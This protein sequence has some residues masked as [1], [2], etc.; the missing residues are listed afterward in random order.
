MKP[1]RGRLIDHIHLRARDFPATAAFYRAV[2]GAL[3]IPLPAAGTMAPPASDPVIPAMS[4]PFCSIGMATTS[5]PLSTVR[6]PAWYRRWSSIPAMHEIGRAVF[7]GGRIA[8]GRAPG[9]RLLLSEG[10][11]LNGEGERT[12]DD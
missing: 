3:A 12:A 7:I 6:R 1:H 9:N 4:R 2:L 8:G 5:R 11:C 10:Q